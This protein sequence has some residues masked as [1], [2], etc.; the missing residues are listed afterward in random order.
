MQRQSEEAAVI[1]FCRGLAYLPCFS[2]HVPRFVCKVGKECG[3]EDPVIGAWDPEN[4][5]DLFQTQ[6]FPMRLV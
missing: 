4:K 6:G 1:P 3:A 2:N 5:N